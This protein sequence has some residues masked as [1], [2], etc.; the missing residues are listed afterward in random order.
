MRRLERKCQKIFKCRNRRKSRVSRKVRTSRK[1]R[2]NKTKV[3]RA[4]LLELDYDFAYDDIF[5]FFNTSVITTFK[6][7]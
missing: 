5:R 1:S 7:W 3:L 6:F 2:K 4:D